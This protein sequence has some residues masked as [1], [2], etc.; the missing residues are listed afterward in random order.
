MA[1]AR[2]PSAILNVLHNLNN[3]CVAAAWCAGLLEYERECEDAACCWSWVRLNRTIP[4]GVPIELKLLEFHEGILKKEKEEQGEV[5]HTHTRRQVMP[6]TVLVRGVLLRELCPPSLCT[7]VA[8]LQRFGEECKKESYIL[9]HLH[10][11]VP[12]LFPFGLRHEHAM[13]SQDAF[14]LN[15]LSRLARATCTLMQIVEPRV[16]NILLMTCIERTVW[17]FTH[18][19]SMHFQSCT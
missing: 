10:V 7:P 3:T 15:L 17:L 6:L 1:V 13:L 16:V 4:V 18:G 9:K 2:A 5:M 19:G 12:S 14:L 8:K 11:L